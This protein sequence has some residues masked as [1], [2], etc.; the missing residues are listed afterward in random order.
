MVSFDDSVMI[1]GFGVVRYDVRPPES[2]AVRLHFLAAGEN[3]RRSTYR[4]DGLSI[5]CK[6]HFLEFMDLCMQYSGYCADI[7]CILCNLCFCTPVPGTPVLMKIRP[8]LGHA[9]ATRHSSLIIH[10][11]HSFADNTSDK[12]AQ[13]LLPPSHPQSV[14]LNE[15][16]QRLLRDSRDKPSTCQIISDLWA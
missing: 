10:H 11:L 4:P 8:D 14:L 3:T 16:T 15:Q 13:I 12:A 6:L 2:A 1:L 9:H 7:L 5:F